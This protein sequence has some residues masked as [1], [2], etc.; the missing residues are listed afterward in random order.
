MYILNEFFVMCEVYVH[1]TKHSVRCL[2]PAGANQVS[3]GA[4]ID[5]IDMYGY[6]KCSLFI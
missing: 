1:V 6:E 5:F 2:S 3:D 4:N